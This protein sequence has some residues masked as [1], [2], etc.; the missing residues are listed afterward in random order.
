MLVLTGLVRSDAEVNVLLTAICDV[1]EDFAPPWQVFEACWR[2]IV[3]QARVHVGVIGLQAP[4]AHCHFYHILVDVVFCH[5]AIIKWK[6]FNAGLRFEVVIQYFSL[7]KC[8]TA[9]SK[10]KRFFVFLRSY[11]GELNGGIALCAVI[12][13]IAKY[14]R[15]N[16]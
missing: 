4:D 3:E 2:L 8:F 12:N 10:S 11:A 7:L 13:L 16:R 5:D 1:E 14:W 9:Q 15:E 6:I